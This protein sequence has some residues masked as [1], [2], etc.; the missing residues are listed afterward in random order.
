[1]PGS[2]NPILVD[3]KHSRSAEHEREKGKIAFPP[4]PTGSSRAGDIEALDRE[5]SGTEFCSSLSFGGK[6][7]RRGRGIDPGSGGGHE[8]GA[9][10]D[11]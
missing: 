8:R 3:P 11:R 2:S 6:G 5:G 4:P 9:R 7:Q 10:Y 1:M